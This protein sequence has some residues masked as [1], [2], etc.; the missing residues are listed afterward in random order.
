MRP[1][2]PIDW[3][4]SGF[5]KG[6]GLY[7]KSL[8]SDFPDAVAF[9]AAFVLAAALMAFCVR[10]AETVIKGS[11]LFMVSPGAC[12]ERMLCNWRKAWGDASAAATDNGAHCA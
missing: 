4:S 10:M 1:L 2:C 9:A 5:P 7:S 3:A 6:A 12:S 8:T 11:L